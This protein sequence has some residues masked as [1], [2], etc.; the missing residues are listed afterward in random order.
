MK[1]LEQEN[2]MLRDKLIQLSQGVNVLLD[3]IQHSK[4]EYY[5][6]SGGDMDIPKNDL[7]IFA[8]V[9]LNDAKISK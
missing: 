7:V 1:N 6:H 2:E 3:H 8:K 9:I 5:K 4:H